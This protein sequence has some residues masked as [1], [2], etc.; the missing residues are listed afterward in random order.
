M[1]LTI[2]CFSFVKRIRLLPMNYR[3]SLGHRAPGHSEI[4]KIVKGAFRDRAESSA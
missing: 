2:V 4:S 1:G 3:P